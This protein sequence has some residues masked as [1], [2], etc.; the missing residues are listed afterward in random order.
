[1]KTLIDKTKFAFLA[2]IVCCLFP[3]NLEAQ[4]TDVGLDSLI[5]QPQN[6]TIEDSLNVFFYT[7]L[8]GNSQN[9]TTYYAWNSED[10]ILVHSY[11]TELQRQADCILRFEDSITIGKLSNGNYTLIGCSY[12]RHQLQDS[13]YTDYGCVC[14]T[15]NF[16]VS[17]PENK[18][19]LDKRIKFN[20]YPNP[21]TKRIKIQFKNK[22]FRNKYELE[23][24]S[25]TGERLLSK[26]IDENTVLDLSDY[27][28]G[29]YLLTIKQDNKIIQSKKII[30]E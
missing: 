24:S 8:Y 9:D 17:F 27:S 11:N 12:Y 5:I 14:D 20:I 28:S 23:I 26:Y 25:I 30:V 18:N 21:V 10:T 15:M 6:P 7:C 4:C 2:G 22:T 1:M 19:Y 16:H 29:I 13:T 3:A